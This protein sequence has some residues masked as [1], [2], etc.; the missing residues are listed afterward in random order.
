MITPNEIKNAYEALGI[1]ADDQHKAEEARIVAA[2][3]REKAYVAAMDDAIGDGIRDEVMLRRKGERASRKQ[4]DSLQKAEKAA[5]VAA[6]GYRQ[7]GIKVDGIIRQL[8]A[9]KLAKDSR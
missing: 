3:A 1:A 7:A 9:E 4:L 8:E 2:I 5:R 6:H